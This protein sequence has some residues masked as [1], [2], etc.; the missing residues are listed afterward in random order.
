[1][2]KILDTIFGY[3]TAE[4]RKDFESRGA[5]KTFRK[6]EVI[7]KRGE[8][9]THCYFVIS[10]ALELHYFNP[11]TL[12]STFFFERLEGSIVGDVRGTIK[13]KRVADLVAVQPSKVFVLKNEDYR[14]LVMSNPNITNFIF[15]YMSQMITGLQV[16]RLG[17]RILDAYGRIAT[18]ILNLHE[19]NKE[20]QVRLPKLKNLASTLHMDNVTL[21]RVLKKMEEDKVISRKNKDV[22][23]LDLA[24]LKAASF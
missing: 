18:F 21:N 8:E 12:E 11:K 2:V 6:G 17:L 16:H 24:A 14:E 7:Y 22:R 1:M 4:Q 15:D 9:A 13:G 3:L 10:G 19:E 5:Y 23:I 20:M